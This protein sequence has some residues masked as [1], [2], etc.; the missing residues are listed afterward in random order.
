MK[1]SVGLSEDAIT[2]VK[3]SLGRHVRIR[4]CRRYDLPK[5]TL[6]NDVIAEEETFKEVLREI[7]IQY[8]FD[9]R[10][11]CLTFGSSRVLAKIMQVPGLTR[12]QLLY[13][14]EKELENYQV[15]EK[16][17]VYDYGVVRRNPGWR[18]GG[19]ILGA[20]IE[21]EKIVNY[22]KIFRECGLEI[23]SMNISLHAMV[24][25]VEHL[26]ELAGKTCIFAVL[27]GRNM[28]MCL[29]TNGVYRHTARSRFLHERGTGELLQE[30]IKDIGVIDSFAKSLET[31]MPVTTVYF[32][33]LQKMEREPLFRSLKEELGMEGRIPEETERFSVRKGLSYHLADYAYATGSLLGR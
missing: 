31:G 32:C 5:G 4:D 17:M 12:K 27:D 18:Q 33:G 22:Q 13:M 28:H 15:E 30:V 8:P 20:A 9:S 23:Q 11:V 19:T 16:E 1:L 2:V 3:G 7:K 14:V 6:I 26:P 25:L 24:R 21:R 10:R 29:Y